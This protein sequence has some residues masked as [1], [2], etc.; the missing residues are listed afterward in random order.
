MAIDRLS[1][2]E[3][4]NCSTSEEAINYIVRFDRA[5]P[6]GGRPDDTIDTWRNN[7]IYIDEQACSLAPDFTHWDKYTREIETLAI[8]ALTETK[9]VIEE[10]LPISRRLRNGVI[11]GISVRT[12]LLK[13]WTI[14]L[15][16][17]RA[18]EGYRRW[19]IQ[20]DAPPQSSQGP[21]H[22]EMNRQ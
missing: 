16:K 20:Q 18:Q 8:N 6:A 3:T 5:F 17:V 15:E 14:N 13:N 12:T 21:L 10:S 19:K 1:G 22:L 7:M 4:S 2:K 11:G 9:R